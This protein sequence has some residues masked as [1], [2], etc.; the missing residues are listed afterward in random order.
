M[1]N[2]MTKPNL[3]IQKLETRPL[4]TTLLGK[5]EHNI[6]SKIEPT[7][8]WMVTQLKN[9]HNAGCTTPKKPTFCFQNNL[10]A[11]KH[12][13]KLIESSEFDIDRAIRNQPDT[14][15]SY[16]SEFRPAH[17]LQKLLEHHEDWNRAKDI[18]E[19][20]SNSESN[21]IDESTRLNDLQSNINFGNHKSA[22]TQEAVETLKKHYG[23]EVKHGWMLPVPVELVPK[24]KDSMVCPIGV[25]TQWTITEWGERIKK[26]RTTHNCSYEGPSGNSINNRFL[27]DQLSPNIYGQALRR[28]LHG[29]AI[30]RYQCPDQK[31]LLG[32]FDG[33]AAFR[34]LHVNGRLAA[35][36]ITI[37][38][39][40]AYILL[41][42]PFGSV[43]APSEWCIFSE[44]TVDLTND[45]LEDETWEPETLHSPHQPMFK[46]PE[47]EPDELPLGQAHEPH[48][49]VP[50]RRAVADGFV[51]DLF[52]ANLNDSHLNNRARNV[53]PLIMHILFRPVATNEPISRDDVLSIRKL[54]GEGTL[55]ERKIILGWILN[56]RL[57]RVFLPDDK[58]K[59]WT[60]EILALLANTKTND[61]ELESIIGKL[62][63]LA[64]LSTCGRYFLNRLQKSLIPMP[65]VWS[66][67]S[68]HIS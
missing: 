27:K 24:I 16:G 29:I 38:L 25:T 63:H 30:M 11:A 65:K 45:L 47:F 34:R 59:A 7:D 22:Q 32:K 60:D 20:G 56:T 57:F 35:A 6:L 8:S 53:I 51:D 19:K 13:A 1:S 4:T 15:V 28:F 14:T 48:V 66:S 5:S 58:A 10:E 50:F 41:R 64:Y 68:C 43:P 26:F 49:D 18:L 36:T 42:L 3:T 62:N 23:K 61:K 44:I 2:V 37:F 31:I 54:L 17:I 67:A 40:I 46:E 21:P 55:A 9:I 12:N 39:H 33:D 52:T